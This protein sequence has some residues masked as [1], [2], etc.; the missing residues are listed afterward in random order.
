MIDPRSNQFHPHFTRQ[1]CWEYI[2]QILDSGHEIEIISLKK[3]RGS[4]GYVMKVEQGPENPKLYIKL[5]IG[6]DRVIGRSF[7]D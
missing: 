1:S 5:Q 2:E 6:R 7:H 4:K 3:P